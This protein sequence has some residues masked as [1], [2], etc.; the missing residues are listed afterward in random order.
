VHLTLGTVDGWL[1]AIEAAVGDLNC[2]LG[3]WVTVRSK[4]L[5]FSLHSGHPSRSDPM[6]EPTTELEVQAGDAV[7]RRFFGFEPATFVGD[8]AFVPAVVRGLAPLLRPT[9]PICSP[10]CTTRSMITLPMLWT[11]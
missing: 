4:P 9:P 10:Q 7:A 5:V 2:R 3:L 11:T 6:A 1:W 8:G